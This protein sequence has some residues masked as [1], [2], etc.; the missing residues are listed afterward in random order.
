M[1]DESVYVISESTLI[2]IADAIRAK[3]GSTEE[4]Q[5]SNMADEIMNLSIGGS[6]PRIVDVS[7]LASAW[8][9]EASP[10][11]QVITVEDSTANTQVNLTPSTEQLVVFREKDVA[12]VTENN[13][14]VISVFAIGE[15][16][17]NDYVIQATVFEVEL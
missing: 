10:Y 12:F 2:A 15:K 8:T 13:D 14:G 5:V 7:L 9:G 1:A 16:P 17:Q 11:S 6:A 4:I 3:S